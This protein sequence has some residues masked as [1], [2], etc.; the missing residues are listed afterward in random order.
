MGTHHKFYLGDVREVLA[1]LPEKSVN[2]CV[3][4]P[5]YWNLRDYGVDGQMGLEKTPEEYVAN[6]VEVF[7]EVKRALRDDGTAW[8]N[9][10][11]SSAH[12]KP[13]LT[14]ECK[15][16]GM[17]WCNEQSHLRV[18]DLKPKDIIGMP[19]RI[20]FTLQADGWYLRQDII[21]AKPNPMPE[22]V[23]DR[24]TRAHEY[25]FLLSKSK[26]Y[27]YDREVVKEPC[28]YDGPNNGVG[29]GHGT[30]KDERQ[31]ERIRKTDKQR[32]HSRRHAGFNDRWDLMTKE[33]QAANGRNK[34]SV[35]TVATESFPEAHFATFP[36]KL[37]EP[38]ILA[39]CPEGGTVLDP[40]GGSGTT[41]LV[42]QKLGRN[43]IYIDLNPEYLQMALKR[44]G[45]TKDRLFDEHTYEVI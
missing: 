42:S 25:I 33:E 40:F 1:K 32:G 31:R 14:K 11:D 4:S 3:T 18:P 17:R 2:C 5:P 22:S 13:R 15:T 16:G 27:Y 26:R 35:W 12:G 36:G 38:C 41:T 8:I 34:R 19:W 30:D 28:S 39:G 24:P 37:I 6:M 21:W 9:L 45:F 44:C 43:S 10:G 20:A 29:F 23:I 7:R